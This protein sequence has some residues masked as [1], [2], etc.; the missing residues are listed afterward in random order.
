M[1]KVRIFRYRRET[2]DYAFADYKCTA[3]TERGLAAEGGGARP[4]DG[5]SIRIMTLEPDIA[6]PG[7]WAAFDTDREEPDKGE[8][9]IVTT[10]RDNRRGG[11]PHWRLIVDG[12]RA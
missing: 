11:L 10:V 6:S 5:G 7:D 3:A 8:D 1:R 4:K 9:Y 12:G 2:G